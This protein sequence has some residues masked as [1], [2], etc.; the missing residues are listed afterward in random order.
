[1][2]EL[3]EKLNAILGDPDAMGQIM[4]L[5]RSLG[6][7]GGSPGSQVHLRRSRERL[8]RRPRRLNRRSPIY[9]PCWARW[10]PG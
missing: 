4:A 6:G 9:P 3:E 8:P 1:M 2:A 10:T 5:A 7:G